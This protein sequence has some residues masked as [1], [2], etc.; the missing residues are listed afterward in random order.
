MQTIT[1]TDPAGN[2]PVTVPVSP[3]ADRE[4]NCLDLIVETFVHIGCPVVVELSI[5]TDGSVV[6][7]KTHFNRRSSATCWMR[8]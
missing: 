1:I 5:R 7:W 8:S 2:H 4:G 3:R 6:F